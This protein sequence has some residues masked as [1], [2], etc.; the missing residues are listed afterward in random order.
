MGVVLLTGVLSL[1]VIRGVPSYGTPL[2]SLG[3]GAAGFSSW[4]L[5]LAFFGLAMRYLDLRKPVLEYAN[6][7]VL[8]S[9][10]AVPASESQALAR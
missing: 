5:I 8:P 6:E 9:P 10:T 2:Y 7:A 3:L 4:C 1:V